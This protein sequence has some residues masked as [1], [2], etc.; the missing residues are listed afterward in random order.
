MTDQKRQRKNPHHR[1][2]RKLLRHS[3]HR[4]EARKHVRPFLGITREVALAA[5]FEAPSSPTSTDKTA[6]GHRVIQMGLCASDGNKGN[7]ADSQQNKDVERQ[8][9]QVHQ[10]V[11]LNL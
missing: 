3:H 8:L 7:N 5:N 4:T 9:L 6:R 11:Q 2:I 10:L 1:L